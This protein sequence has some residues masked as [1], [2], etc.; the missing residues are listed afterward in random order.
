MKQLRASFS[1]IL[2][3]ILLIAGW[4]V[5]DVGC[6]YTQI[7]ALAATTARKKRVHQSLLKSMENIRIANTENND[8]WYVVCSTKGRGFRFEYALNQLMVD[9]YIPTRQVTL[10]TKQGDQY[11]EATQYVLDNIFFIRGEESIDNIVKNANFSIRRYCDHMRTNAHDD[12]QIRRCATVKHQEL[13]AFRKLLSLHAGDIKMLDDPI[14]S[15]LRHPHVRII[16][17]PFKGYEGR[18]VRIRKDRKFV[19]FFSGKAFC[20]SG[21]DR[22]LLEKIDD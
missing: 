16:R 22:S 15:F 1:H 9:Y 6:E 19:I 21:I 11:E 13:M 12:G 7:H 4:H 18:I 17:G 10:P 5:G 14:E 2:P 3:S 20:V 8:D